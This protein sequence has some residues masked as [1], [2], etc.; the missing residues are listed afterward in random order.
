MAL[1]PIPNRDF[2]L[3]GKKPVP[4]QIHRFPFPSPQSMTESGLSRC[5]Q[6]AR[7]NPPS[8]IAEHT[9]PLQWGQSKMSSEVTDDTV[10]QKLD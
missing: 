6:H 3:H 4:A 5:P 9:L 1:P 2:F 10:L 8:S 7:M